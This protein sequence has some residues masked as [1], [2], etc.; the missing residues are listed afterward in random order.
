MSF[1][2]SDVCLTAAV[3][4]HDPNQ[5]TYTTAKLL[6][7]L[8]QAQRDLQDA[9]ILNDNAYLKEKYSSV[10][11]VAA[12]AASIVTIPTDFVDPI[13]LWERPDGGNSDQWQEVDIVEFI[14][15][16]T[17]YPEIRYMQWQDDTMK[18]N[19]PTTAREVRLFYHSGLTLVS[20]PTS[21]IP[22]QDWYS[23]L[24]FRTAAIAAV[25]IG[26]NETRGAMLQS[27]AE[28]ALATLLSR[29]V[30]DNQAFPTRPLGYRSRQRRSY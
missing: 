29:G 28:L 1:Q 19:P 3:W 21:V 26:E 15:D 23:Y 6:E 25:V 12:N 14:E 13:K 8:K 5:R 10:I 18:I 2:A 11:D 16:E 20:G 17:L 22:E 4:C 30:K 27:E 9:L 7:M 24:G